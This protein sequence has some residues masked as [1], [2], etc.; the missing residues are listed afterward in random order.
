MLTQKGKNIKLCLGYMDR[1][2]PYTNL[3]A[4]IIDDQIIQQP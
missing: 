4:V 2:S 1:L 3:S